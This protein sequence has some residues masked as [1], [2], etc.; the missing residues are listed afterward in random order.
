MARM[1]YDA[2]ARIE[3]LGGARSPII[4]YGS[5]GHAHALNLR[6][7]EVDVI[8]GLPEKSRSRAK[9]EAEGLTVRHARGGREAGRHHHD[10]GARHRAGPALP[11]RTSSRT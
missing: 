5:Q 7:N 6:D 8:V 10:A 9:A 3:D 11:R 2:D 4:G 1:Y